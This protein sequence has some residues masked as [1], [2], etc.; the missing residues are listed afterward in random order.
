MTP[1]RQRLVDDLR[2]R[3][4]SPRTIERYV[5]LVAR[6]AKYFGKSPDVLGAE[7]MRAFQLHLLEKKVSWSLFKSSSRVSSG[8]GMI[9]NPQ[10]GSLVRREKRSWRQPSPH[11]G[12]AR[13]PNRRVCPGRRS[14]P[15]VPSPG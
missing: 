2:L 13:Y 8:A 14:I 11:P 1:L 4:Y 6:F 5:S 15:S 10:S 12:G 7:E 3:N 9:A